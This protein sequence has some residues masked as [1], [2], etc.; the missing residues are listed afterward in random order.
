MD[1]VEVSREL[2]DRARQVQEYVR[3]TNQVV[4]ELIDRGVEIQ[5]IHNGKPLPDGVFGLDFEIRMFL[6]VE[7]IQL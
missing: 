6:P 5:Y 4:K 2:R 3:A 7:P 1:S